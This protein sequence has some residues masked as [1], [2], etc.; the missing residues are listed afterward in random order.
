MNDR[1]LT[2][3]E[4]IANSNKDEMIKEFLRKNFVKFYINIY[5]DET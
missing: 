4:V 1:G 2:G 5:K 3:E